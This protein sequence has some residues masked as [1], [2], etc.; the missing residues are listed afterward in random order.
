MSKY[1]I[2]LTIGYDGTGYQGWQKQKNRETIQGI[3]EDRI[4]TVL[5]TQIKLIGASRT[6]A[7]VHALG[8]VANFT[9]NK[10]LSLDRL[11]K[12][13]NSFLPP[14]I[15]IHRAEYADIDFNSRYWA[16]SKLYR[17][18][19]ISQKRPT[20]RLYSWQFKNKI[21]FEDLLELAPMFIGEHDFSGFSK[22]VKE[23]PNRI[24]SILSSRWVVEDG[25]FIYEVEGNRFLHGMV[26]GMVGAMVD[27]ASGKFP[28]LT[29]RMILA[30]G[31]RKTHIRMAPANG[32]CL[33][34]VNY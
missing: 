16:R 24:C 33:V 7:G 12:R 6:D 4:S 27:S 28:I 10:K 31:D 23:K 18:T 5:R 14:Q 26:R 34:R 3:L 30:E 15:A 17:Y 25:S 1:N 22:K 32:L 19:I 20:M 29:I 2:K 8:Q 9:I 11:V 21:N 13:L